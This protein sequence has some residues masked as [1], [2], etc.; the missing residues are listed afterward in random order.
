MP[1]RR[2]TC[3]GSTSRRVEV[4]TVVEDLALHLGARDQVVHPVEAA[5]VGALA[6]ARRADEGGD[7]A[8]EDLHVDALESQL[9]AVG[10]VDV[11]SRRRP[12]PSLLCSRGRRRGRRGAI[13][14]HGRSTP[15]LSGCI[16][17]S[18]S[19]GRLTDPFDSSA[20]RR[21]GW[22]SAGDRRT[23][24]RPSAVRASGYAAGLLDLGDALCR[25]DPND[26]RDRRVEQ[27]QPELLPGLADREE[28]EL[29]ELLGVLRLAAG[30]SP[31]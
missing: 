7:L 24:G 21:S 6:A 22:S 31:T 20:Y 8:L 10:D 26:V 28:E 30:R 25:G 19:I 16:V 14:S 5:D 2:R 23:G 15:R 1:I 13:E 4:L 29:L 9:S 3:T 27:L 12:V 11:R 17:A 18:S